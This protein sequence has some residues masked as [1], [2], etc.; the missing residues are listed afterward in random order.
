MPELRRV[1]LKFSHGIGDG[2][3]FSVIL[4]HL[5]KYRPDWIV[6]VV[7]GRGKHT[8]FRG[9]CNA[10]YFDGQPR[11]DESTYDE[12]RWVNWVENYNGYSDKPNSKITNCLAEEFHIP[13]DAIL[14]RY[15]IHYTP[16]ECDRAREWLADVG[17]KR[18]SNGRFQAVGL[19][20]EG[21][22][23]TEKKNI[24]HHFARAVCEAV[25]GVGGKVI[26]FDW[27]RRSPIP[28]GVNVINP[29]VG[30][31]DLWGNFGSGDAGMIAAVVDQL[32]G[33][34]GIDSGPG[35][36]ASATDT[37]T[38]I[39]WTGH[40]PLQFHDPAPNT[41]HLVP[42]GF[43]GTA[44]ISG[45]RERLAFFLK[46]Y[47]H[48]TYAKNGL[49]FALCR[50]A[51][52]FITGQDMTDS[53]KNGLVK[54]G[55]FW[56]RV[57]NFDQDLVIIQDVFYG[58]CYHTSLYDLTQWANVVDVGGHIGTFPTLV[59]MRNPQ[60]N[61]AVVEACPENIP[62]LTANVG[63]F[64]H[65]VAGAMTYEPGEL[66]LL[67]SVRPSCESTGGSVVVRREEL[68]NPNH[69]L[70]Q[71]GYQYW[72]DLRPL[73]KVTLGEVMR[74]AGMTH[75]DCLKLDC[76]GAEYSILENAP[77][78]RHHVR[79]IFGE[80]HDNIRWEELR[81]RLFADW[82][83]GKIYEAD[84]RGLFNMIN[85]HFDPSKPLPKPA[86]TS[87]PESEAGIR[88]IWRYYSGTTAEAEIRAWGD[89]TPRHLQQAKSVA[90][91]ASQ[92]G[93]KHVF[94]F[95][96]GA[97]VM[98][99]H[100]PR[101]LAYMG[102]DRNERFIAE[103][104]AK[105][106][107]EGTAGRTFILYDWRHNELFAH[108]PGVV[109]AFAIFKHFGLDEFD[110]MFSKFAANVLPGGCAVFDVNLAAEE[111]DDGIEFH[112]SHVTPNHIT[113]LLSHH[114]LAEVTREVNWEGITRDTGRYIF[115][116]TFTATRLA[117]TSEPGF[118]RS[119]LAIACDKL[120][121]VRGATVEFVHA[122]KTFNDLSGFINN[123][124]EVVICDNYD[125]FT[126][127][128]RNTNLIRWLCLENGWRLRDLVLSTGERFGVIDKNP[129]PGCEHG[130]HGRHV[131]KI[132]TT[133]GVGDSSWIITKLDGFCDFIGAA[134]CDLDTCGSDRAKGYLSL[135]PRVRNVGA[136]ALE[137]VEHPTVTKEGAYNYAPSQPNWHGCYDFFLQANGHLERGNRLEEWFPKVPTDF[138]AP[139]RFAELA[140]DVEFAE[141]FATRGRY[142]TFFAGPIDGNGPHAGHNRGGQWTPLDWAHVSHC[143]ISEGVRVVLIGY[144]PGDAEY[145]DEKLYPAGF[146]DYGAEE[147]IGAWPLS[148]TL[149]VL[150]RSAGH[151]GYQSGLGILSTY[152]GKPCVLFWNRYGVPLN[153]EGAT[154]REEMSGAWVP[155]EA[156]GKPHTPGV[157]GKNYFGAIY[158]RTDAPTV[159]EFIVRRVL[160]T[161]GK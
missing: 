35:K 26:L 5:R 59:H 105:C 136:S 17:V 151:V 149:S 71:H 95:A 129:Q 98:A 50:K 22:T 159:A 122:D 138:E 79:F 145:R 2:A 152:W 19:H 27:D 161:K 69:P 115:E 12:A 131:V 31:S 140:E 9:L 42:E 80:Y 7:S 106:P 128:H 76:E 29:G 33:F 133:A 18:L 47:Q 142:V 55:P 3:Q 36:I 49:G 97:G 70:R 1:L 143:L 125:P 34:V 86:Q 148:R 82:Q 78:V 65:V 30:P 13:Y 37:P 101:E 66:A 141:A 113:Q 104:R 144:N 85:P 92:Y 53:V 118:K 127:A 126:T 81:G 157:A 160:E 14:G 146:F 96:C 107:H 153:P 46:S 57:D 8:A 58:D 74:E 21:N 154:F 130:T 10:T 134:G 84:G 4:K 100:L 120:R 150:K 48:E 40:N 147:Y 63:E 117:Q 43:D 56:V 90:S 99:R 75:V 123:A 25:V 135:L 77:E 94:E 91:A 6:D 93:L 124:A 102:L 114:G 73:R 24:G 67:N 87:E 103:A 44:P 112:H 116:V 119:E 23:S 60:A 20:Y 139:V 72:D 68:A 88:D 61:I 15:E 155:L 108:K 121:D 62:A 89:G 28:D 41:L 158:G 83:Y 39:V 109:C 132:A 45:D 11:P 54:H 38:V 156:P 137:I 111:F 64:A 110:A 16:D 51:S 32:S 52:A